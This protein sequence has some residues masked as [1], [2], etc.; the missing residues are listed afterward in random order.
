MKHMHEPYTKVSEC[1]AVGLMHGDHG[2]V[3]WTIISILTSVPIFGSL[4]TKGRSP[5]S[6][7]RY[8]A[9]M[10]DTPT[11]LKNQNTLLAQLVGLAG[12]WGRTYQS[13]EI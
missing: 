12:V 7:L 9:T 4:D 5:L 2:F 10:C 6:R 13:R 8:F 11:H 1:W 3:F